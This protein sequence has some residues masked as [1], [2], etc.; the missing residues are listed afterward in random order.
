M[1]D[2]NGRRLDG[3]PNEN[4][5]FH[6][7][8]LNLYLYLY[9]F[10]SLFFILSSC[11]KNSTGPSSI[12]FDAAF[13]G[14][15][16]SDSTAIG[17]EVLADGSSKTLAVDTAGTLQYATAGSGATNGLSLTLLSGKDGNL[18]ARVRYVVTG[19]ID[20]TLSI[21]GVYTFSN[22]N[23][24]LSITFPNP[25]TGG[26]LYTIV[27]RRTSIGAIVR[28][29]SAASGVVIRRNRLLLPLFFRD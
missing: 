7:L 20:T 27:F 16:Y 5:S 23:N 14:V 29:G 1:R 17:F 12:P 15:W 26:Q 8:N 22:G 10:L 19:F 11:K 25:T 6:G 9:L 4:P 28:A 24:T 2:L 3:S 21:P 13:V 18:M